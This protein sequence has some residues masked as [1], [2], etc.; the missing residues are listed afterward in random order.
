MTTLLNQVSES[1]KCPITREYFKEP[2]TTNTGQTYEKKAILEWLKKNKT[3]PLTRELITNLS[4]NVI[5][6]YISELIQRKKKKKSK[7]MKN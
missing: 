6:K 4:P 3:D 2:V 7:N 1:L 5:L